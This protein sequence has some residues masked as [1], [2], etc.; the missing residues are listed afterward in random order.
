MDKPNTPTLPS[1]VAQYAGVLCTLVSESRD[2]ESLRRHIENILK[3][4]AAEVGAADKE[5]E[6]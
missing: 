4:F 2:E 5:S 3:L 6:K 1:L